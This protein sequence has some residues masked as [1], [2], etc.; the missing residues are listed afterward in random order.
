[1]ICLKKVEVKNIDFNYITSQVLKGVTFTASEGE[2]LGVI[3][4]NG[5]GKSTLLRVMSKLLLPKVGTVYYED[6][7]LSTLSRRDVARRVAVVPQESPMGFSFT[8]SDIVLMGR[9][10]HMGLLESEGKRDYEIA[11][12]SMEVTNTYHL[13]NRVV[14]QLSGGERQRVIIARALA[15]SPKVL[16]LDEP[17]ANLDI[18]HQ[19]EI[20][21]LVKKLTENGLIVICS[22][23][24]LNL[25]SF[26]ADRLL[27]LKEGR[28]ITWGTPA[29]VLT[30]E[31]VRHIFGIDVIIEPHPVT[32]VPCII[33]TP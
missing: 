9:N 32:G 3:G 1:V 11:R 16:L 23:H 30:E 18:H 24:D 17:T 10:P 13:R 2:F 25:A 26:Y 28:I 33:L 8:V 5:S 7:D 27:A 31:H 19:I 22:I 6:C 21:D 4:P 15:Q 12:R 20:L 29:H 14:T